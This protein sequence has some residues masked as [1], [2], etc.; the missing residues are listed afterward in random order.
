MR[1]RHLFIYA[2]IVL[3]GLWIYTNMQSHQSLIAQQLHYDDAVALRDHRVVQAFTFG[4]GF[5][6]EIDILVTAS[7]RKPFI[8]YIQLF[9]K[10]RSLLATKA[11]S[12]LAQDLTHPIKL[13]FDSSTIGSLP[14]QKYYLSLSSSA[15]ADPVIWYSSYDTYPNGK[16]IIDGQHS[17]GDLY[18]QAYTD[19]LW[20]C[21]GSS[22]ANAVINFAKLLPWLILM[23][24]LPGV[25]ILSILPSSL[26]LG[27]IGSVFALGLAIHPLFWLFANMLGIAVN[28][29]IYVLFLLLLVG[30]ILIRLWSGKKQEGFDLK[31]IRASLRLGDTDIL[32]VGVVTMGLLLFAVRNFQYPLWIDSVKHAHIIKA[33][34]STGDIFAL[35]SNGNQPEFIYH[36]GY[37]TIIAAISFFSGA[38]LNQVMLYTGQFILFLA[39]LSTSLLVGRFVFTREV[40]VLALFLVLYLFT[41]PSHYVA[42]GRYTLLTA[43][44]ILPITIMLTLAFLE[45]P[46]LHLGLLGVA[47]IGWSGMFLTHYRVTAFGAIFVAAWLTVNKIGHFTRGRIELVGA[48]RRILVLSLFSCLIDLAWII[49]LGRSV[50]FQRV[51]V[52][53]HTHAKDVSSLE[54]MAL[55]DNNL[56]LKSVVL[57]LGFIVVTLGIKKTIKLKHNKMMLVTLTWLVLLF[58]ATYPAVIVPN[59]ISLFDSLT[60]RSL[61]YLPATLLLALIYDEVLHRFPFLYRQ[62][63][64]RRLSGIALILVP[65]LCFVWRG[66]PPAILSPLEATS[67]VSQAEIKAFAWI[68]DNTPQNTVFLADA[69]LWADNTY[70]GTD[71]G[72]WI[73]VATGRQ[74]LPP[75]ADYALQTPD[76]VK[77][78]NAVLKQVAKGTEFDQPD[79]LRA[80]RQQ[81]VTYVYVGPH[82]GAISL[83]AMMKSPHY[84]PIYTN[85]SVWLFA[86]DYSGSPTNR[87]GGGC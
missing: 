39:G 31:Q 66:T 33:L 23:L 9:D 44:A 49:H 8:L 64:R 61:L 56:F 21:N 32:L 12:I 71:G 15:D 17:Q 22:W 5:P 86:F 69:R 37:H 41:F 42:W 81:H 74:V 55:S 6:D 38:S 68:R 7:E 11:E 52:W 24:F 14:D 79:F 19:C 78:I 87:L 29:D 75:T 20:L 54:I 63:D 76:K 27:G 46:T 10:E 59:M 1:L 77:K 30:V 67:L 13:R 72:Y 82:D 70:V 65:V 3:V 26:N 51:L 43:M 25:A 16:L 62:P 57:I 73:N 35:Q 36:F 80:L 53:A 18:F 58:L 40:Q 34:I 48:L 83:C 84:R 45:Y 60:A 50:T 2:A 47:A 85:G 28:R 4:D